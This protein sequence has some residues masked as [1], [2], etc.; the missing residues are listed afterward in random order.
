[1]EL[2][3]IRYCRA[4]SRGLRGKSPCHCLSI[5]RTLEGIG[6][7]AIFN[8]S[9]V[10]VAVYSRRAANLHRI[11]KTFEKQ[12]RKQS[13]SLSDMSEPHE[14]HEPRALSLWPRVTS[15]DKI[16]R[17]PLELKP[18]PDCLPVIRFGFGDNDK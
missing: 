17:H 3:I 8:D 2:G 6:S 10:N 16:H 7:D 13:G 12:S 11:R 9:T 15:P 4:E 14:P 5:S 18:G 1:M